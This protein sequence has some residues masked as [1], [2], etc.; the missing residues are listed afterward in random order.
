MGRFF[1][2]WHAGVQGK[3]NAYHNKVQIKESM[4]EFRTLLTLWYALFL[5]CTPTCRIFSNMS[6]WK[7][8]GCLKINFWVY[9]KSKSLWDSKIMEKTFFD[10]YFLLLISD[11][12]V[13]ASSLPLR[14]IFLDLPGAQGRVPNLPF[15]DTAK[16]NFT[17]KY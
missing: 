17:H 1:K 16:N 12:E 9:I 10:M 11:K 6:F 2:N 4:N 15:P 8:L 7:C 5:L 14:S 3:N 13:M